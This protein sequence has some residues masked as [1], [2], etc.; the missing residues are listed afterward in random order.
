MQ[1]LV[2]AFVS[3]IQLAI[4]QSQSL[5]APHLAQLSQPARAFDP[6]TFTARLRF[7]QRQVKLL[8]NG[9]KWRRLAKSVRALRGDPEL[10]G[11]GLLFDEVIQREL[12][13]RV[14]LPVVEASRSTGGQ[15]V[16]EKVSFQMR[17]PACRER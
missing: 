5:I 16:A 6:S 17:G 9:I 10:A 8:E 4:T 3:R 2:Q 15:A 1:S 12:V 14:I 7:L 11:A 13:A